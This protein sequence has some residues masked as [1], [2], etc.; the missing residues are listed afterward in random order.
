[1]TVK[2]CFART[3]W[4]GHSNYVRKT[5]VRAGRKGHGKLLFTLRFPCD[6]DRWD[7]EKM[8]IALRRAIRN[9]GYILAN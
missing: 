5:T 2:L 3:T 1:M 4:D 7:R 9:S 6:I 8:F